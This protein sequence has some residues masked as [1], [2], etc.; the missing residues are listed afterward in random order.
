[1]AL[2]YFCG[3]SWQVAERWMGRVSAI[4]GGALLLILALTWLW[5]RRPADENN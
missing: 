2:G 4:I 5:R 3:A 1:V